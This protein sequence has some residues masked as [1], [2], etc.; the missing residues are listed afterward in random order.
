VKT[1]APIVAFLHVSRHVGSGKQ[2]KMFQNFLP[3][4]SACRLPAAEART[5]H[6]FDKD[7]ELLVNH[8]SSITVTLV[9]NR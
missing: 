4:H 8:V 9:L 1:R 2:S 6:T 5:C 3:L 7:I